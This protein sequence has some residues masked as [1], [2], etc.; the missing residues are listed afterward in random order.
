MEKMA[1]KLRLKVTYGLVGNDVIE[2][3]SDRFFYSSNMNVSSSDR[4]QVFGTSWGNCGDGIPTMRHPSEFM[5]WRIAKKPNIGFELGLF[6]S[7]GVRLDYSREDRS[8]ILVDRSF[9]STTMGLGA[10]VRASVGGVTSHGVDLSVNYDH[11]FDNKIWLQGYGNLTY[12]INEFKVTD[13]PDYAA[14]GLPW[15]SRAGYSLNQ[16]WEYIAE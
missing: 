2:S 16:Q 9:I 14:T 1:N 12:A 5:A 3:N 10:S 4:G 15:G 7:L 8:K 13:R 6:N 11:W